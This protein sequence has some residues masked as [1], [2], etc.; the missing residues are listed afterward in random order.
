MKT[1]ISKMMAIV[2]AV[3]LTLTVAQAEVLKYIPKSAKVVITANP[4]DLIKKIKTGAFVDEKPAQKAIK[5]YEK[6]L[7]ELGLTEDM[8]PSEVASYFN[9]EKDAAFIVKTNITQNQLL[10]LLDKAVLS[11]K[12]R[13]KNPGYKKEII[14]GEEVIVLFE[15]DANGK[16]KPNSFVIKYITN[17]I[18]LMTQKD[19]L[20]I[21]LQSLKEDSILTNPSFLERQK[22]LDADSLFKVYVALPKKGDPNQGMFA[23]ITSNPQVQGINGAALAFNIIGS[24]TLKLK[25]AIDCDNPGKAAGLTMMA[26]MGLMMPLQKF[27]SNPE[28]LGKIKNAI[29]ITTENKSIVV[30]V[31]VTKALI[32]EVIAEQMKSEMSRSMSPSMQAPTAPSMP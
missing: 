20:S 28:L 7:D 29:S 22:S 30:S 24:D 10:P 2:S 31:T 5:E 27:Q 14:M 26:N 13:G 15:L 12:E 25:L 19:S 32:Q 11:A 18:A 6:A 8:L 17:N 4:A 1:R 23:M 21:V 9:T 16:E 3:A